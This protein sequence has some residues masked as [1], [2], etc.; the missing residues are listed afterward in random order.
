MAILSGIPQNVTYQTV[1]VAQGGGSL[2]LLINPRGKINQASEVTG[3]KAAGEYFC[4]GWKAGASGAEVYVDVDGIRL[5]SGSIKQLVPNTLEVGRTIR[6]NMDIV[7][8]T[9]T[10][11]INGGTDTATSDAA[12]YIELEISGNNSKFT[13]VILAE[14]VNLPSYQQAQD[15]LT[16]CLR[17]YI[18]RSYDETGISYIDVSQVHTN[19]ALNWLDMNFPVVM[20]MTPAINLNASVG[21][22]VNVKL[23]G[24]IANYN[25]P[26]V[27]YSYT[28]DA[29]P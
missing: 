16:P 5:V 26:F 18:K 19:T 10:M 14:S 25:S 1:N 29:R 8:G 3:I 13:R 2:N 20:H 11:S 17:F 6:S 15:E 9:P 23:D 27:L 28:A 4:D 24:F 22:S 12:T 21:P 7:S